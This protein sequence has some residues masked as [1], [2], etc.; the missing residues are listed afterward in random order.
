MLEVFEMFEMLGLTM[1]RVGP[2]T[3]PAGR[4]V[5]LP[6]RGVTYTYE[7]GAPPDSPTLLLLHGL[8]ASGALNW[9]P[10]FGP[11]SEGFHVVAMDM[12]G[13]GRGIPA[14]GA[15]RLADCAD[16]AVALADALE[17]DRFIPVGYSLGGSVA[18][19]IWHRHR[20]RVDGMVLCATSRN[21]RGKPRERWFYA[22]LGGALLALTVAD[23]LRHPAGAHDGDGDNAK[24]SDDDVMALAADPLIMDARIPRWAVDEMRRCSPAAMLR[25]VH[26]LGRFSSHDWVGNIDVPTAVVVTTRDRLVAPHRQLKLAQAIPGATVHAAAS[27][28]AACVLGARVFVPALVEACQSVADR[29]V[30]RLAA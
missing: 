15:Y 16:D 26:A 18:Q 3:L 4:H 19:L 28:H 14:D 25:A 9:F 2:D 8:G 22:G 21:F 10:S 30:G 13:H 23:W 27:D 7:L 29:I 17:I 5:P 20:D 11:L 12:R 1:R 24:I 6:G